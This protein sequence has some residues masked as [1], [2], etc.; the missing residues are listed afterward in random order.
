MPSADDN[1]KIYL[2]GLCVRILEQRA[3]GDMKISIRWNDFNIKNNVRWCGDIVLN[4]KVIVKPNCTVLLD[5]A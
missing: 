2:N 4:E 1:R 5:L 3:N